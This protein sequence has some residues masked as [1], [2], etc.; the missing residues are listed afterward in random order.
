MEKAV[1][2]GNFDGVHLG[3][4]ALLSLVAEKALKNKIESVAYIFKTH[5]QIVLGNK[6]YNLIMSNSQ[7][8]EEILS[9]GI[10]N[11]IFEETTKKILQTSPRDFV[12]EILKK[13]LGASVVVAG[14][15]YSF[16]YKGAGN[17]EIL[18]RFCSEAGIKCHII[19]KV[20][21]DGEEV[22]SSKIRSLLLA[23]DMEKAALL[24]GKPYSI[25]GI[26]EKGKQL[27]REIGFNTANV[28]FHDNALIPQNGVYESRA[29][30]DGAEYKSITNIGKN[31]TVENIMPRSE[32]HLI[33]FDGD[34]YGKEIKIEILKKI[35]NEIKFNSVDDL[36]IQIEK[37]INYIKGR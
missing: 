13:K 37:D 15:N 17:S 29:Y 25:K 10:S 24:L 8:E 18:L 16:G 4:R 30:V 27:G 33:G 22:S 3:H 6:E 31:P 5:P 32:S 28:S 1:A 11:V 34:L 7:K 21:C 12:F 19:D 20:M 35:R 23:G 2:I 36:K 14:Y 9:L 26:V